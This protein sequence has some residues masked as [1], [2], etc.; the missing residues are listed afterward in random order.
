[1]CAVAAELGADP[2]DVYLGARATE[3]EVKKLSSEGALAHVRVVHFATHGLLASETEEFARALSEPALLLSPPDTATPDDDGLL[4]ASEVSQLKLDADWVVLSACNTASGGENGSAE[5]LS[6]LAQGFL[7]CW[8]PSAACI[9]LVCRQ[10]RRH[11][12]HDGAFGELKRDLR[13]TEQKHS[14]APCLP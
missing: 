5:A 8:N 13:W 12:A 1:M 3:T 7:L 4:T 6:G 2:H 9:A 10:P 14:G 11:G